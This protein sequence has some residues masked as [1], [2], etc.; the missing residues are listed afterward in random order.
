M[1]DNFNPSEASVTSQQIKQQYPHICIEISG[2]INE[3]TIR[4]YLCDSIDVVSMGCLTHGYG[5][6]DFSLKIQQNA[7]CPCFDPVD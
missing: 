7:Y 5:V 1:L 2:G 4:E 6:I 3:S